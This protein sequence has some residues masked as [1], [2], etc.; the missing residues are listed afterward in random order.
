LTLAVKD[1]PQGFPYG[2][3]ARNADLSAKPAK[4]MLKTLEAEPKQFIYYNNGI[5]LVVESLQS[6]RIDGGDFEVI[7]KYSCRCCSKIGFAQ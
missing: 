2:P 6:K 3:N 1:L 7:V 5:M 4:A